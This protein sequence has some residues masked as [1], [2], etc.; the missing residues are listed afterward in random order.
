MSIFC[1][2]CPGRVDRG[3]R[4]LTR[5]IA[6]TSAEFALEV[7]EVVSN[8]GIYLQAAL[9]TG[10]VFFLCVVC[11]L[12]PD[13]LAQSPVR[14]PNARLR[15]VSPVLPPVSVPED[16]TL[17]QVTEVR[18]LSPQAA[19]LRKPVQL[20]GIVTDLSGYRNSF[21]FQDAT[22][23]ISVD[24]TDNANVHTG[25]VVEITGT[26]GPGLF[27]PVVLASYVKVVGHGPP[28]P[29][30]RVNYGD[31]FGGAQDGQW[32]AMAG[33]VHSAR[34]AE[35]D[36][37]I[38]LWLSLEIGGGSVR[39]LI[40]DFKGIDLAHVVDSKIRVQGVAA[41]EFNQKRQFSGLDLYVPSRQFL[42]ILEP[43]NR[44]PFDVPATPVANAL[45]F[46]QTQHR[47]KIVGVSTYQAAGHAIYLQDGADGIRVQSLSKQSIG[48]GR[49]L[50][51]VGFPVLGDYAPMLEDALF[52]DLGPA[53]FVKPVAIVASHVITMD[54]D[55]YQVPY[56]QQLVRLRGTV[57]ES[58]FEAGQRV[59]LL[60]DDGQVFEAHLLQSAAGKLPELGPGSVLQLTGIC[61]VHAG[62]DL[63]PISFGILLRDASDIVV[64]KRASWWS[65]THSIIVLSVLG[66]LTILVTL[67]VLILRKRVEQQTGIIRASEERLRDL[68]YHDF[69]TGL[70]NRLSFE[71]RIIECLGR[72][73]SEQLSA[74]FFTID[75]DRFKRINDTYGHEFGDECLKVVANRLRTI[76]RKIDIIARIGGEE[77]AIVVGGLR[78]QESAHRIS[79][80]I[81]GLFQE[82]AH[83]QGEAIHL[84]VSIGGAVY[85]DDGIDPAMLRKLSDRALY[86][87]KRL[88][89]NRTIF[90]SSEL[91]L[92][93]DSDSD[94]Q[95][96]FSPPASGLMTHS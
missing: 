71:D 24:R 58:H 41:T 49:R 81:F 90:A 38:V 91:C 51:A 52:R 17:T 28:P 19:E 54:G 67:W 36:G 7:T 96:E 6:T 85:P 65:R 60:Q 69:L 57:E 33:I 89:R 87:A 53:P 42:D 61:T 30:R 27:A 94:T 9:T 95:F 14:A 93:M 4:I 72:C 47:V 86:A 18:R 77:F 79:D 15:A 82:E 23:G 34:I 66:G 40:H 22:G 70:P 12:A 73:R 39:V 64:V 78:N 25:D 59:W 80:A 55:F 92:A 62:A 74:V 5:R 76:V 56:D 50:E 37:H 11:P 1:P 43:A 32:V 44:D 21:F 3:A 8:S 88:G 29:A 26:S 31:L 46:G 84:T 48:P 2:Q 13:S 75:V 45:Q 20:R 35:E 68:A 10:L 83:I 63:N 16:A